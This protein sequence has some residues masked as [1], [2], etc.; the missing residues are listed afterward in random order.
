MTYS[1]E[2]QTDN[3]GILNSYSVPTWL[4]VFL[5]LLLS[6]FV[7]FC[8]SFHINF[9][10]NATPLPHPP[11]PSNIHSSA[12]KNKSYYQYGITVRTVPLL[13]LLLYLLCAHYYQN[14]TNKNYKFQITTFTYNMQC[15]DLA[16][17][18]STVQ[19]SDVISSNSS[20]YNII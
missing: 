17:I 7:L 13:L 10:S 20:K 3:N 5:S 12:P 19:E 2:R 1:L 9:I 8:F 15:N 6:P 16:W 18:H 4:L 14:K 11:E